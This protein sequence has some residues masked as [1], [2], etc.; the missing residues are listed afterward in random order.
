MNIVLVHGILGYSQVT[1]P[2][3]LAPLRYFNGV[4]DYLTSHLPAN[5]KIHVPQLDP[6]AGTEQRSSELRVS[7]QGALAQGTL[8]PSQPI[9]IIA[10]S[11]GGLDA[12]RM[13]SKDSLISGVAV[14]TVS[15]I[16]TPHLGSPIAD[17]VAGELVPK[18]P[19][20]TP[21]LDA[22]KTLLG[23]VL[24]TFG[25]S[26]KGLQDLTTK[27][28]KQFNID[29][30]DHDGVKYFSYGGKGR[31]GFFH[32]TS[33][34]FFP[35]YEFIRIVDGEVSDGVVSVSSAQWKNFDSDLWPGDHLD[36]V[37]HDLDHVERPSSRELLD[38][39]LAIV[40][41]F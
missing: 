21:V 26:L 23:D 34:F 18:L 19:L 36:E 27:S 24:G 14:K 12:R 25:V 40:A 22:A 6:T 33:H 17:V 5:T 11:M 38:R 30:P 3:P 16:G 13:I 4:A 39:Y 29:F 31:P 10:H 1:L 2:G 9:H 32:P 7:I 41:R 37:G 20:L 15:T 28:A 8:D 35:Y